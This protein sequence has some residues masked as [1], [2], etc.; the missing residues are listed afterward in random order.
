MTEQTAEDIDMLWRAY[1]T[2]KTVAV[3]NRIAACRSGGS[4]QQRLF[5]TVGRD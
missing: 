2:E 4:P 3:R 5:R 1:E